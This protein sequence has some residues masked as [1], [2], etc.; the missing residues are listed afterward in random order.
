MTGRR[1]AGVLGA[2]GGCVCVWHGSMGV[3]C[4]V[5]LACVWCKEGAS[6]GL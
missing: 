4:L 3:T 6:E 1:A 5:L 2:R